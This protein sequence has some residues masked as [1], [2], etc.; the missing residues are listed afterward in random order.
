VEVFE[1]TTSGDTSKGTTPVDASGAW[2]KTLSGV[3]GGSHTYKGKAKD[4]A[5]NTSGFSNSR[6]VVVDKVKPQV[7]STT[8]L[9][10]TTGVGLGTNLTATFSEKMRASSI[11]TTTFKLYRVKSD[12]TQTQITNVAVSLSSDG[13]KA[14]LN[15]FGVQTPTLL[16]ARNTKYKGVVTTGAMD[17]AG[18]ALAQQKSWTF[19]TRS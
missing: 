2:T 14:T 1:A 16:L 18:N 19:T 7:S 9:A 6:T 10:G 13:L 15:P 11:N 17:L 12:G 4:A 3:S 8:P 5:G